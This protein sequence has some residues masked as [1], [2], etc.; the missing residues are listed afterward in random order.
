MVPLYC[1]FYLCLSHLLSSLVNDTQL[2]LSYP[3]WLHSYIYIYLF[4]THIS[5]CGTEGVASKTDIIFIKHLDV[6]N[7]C[8]YSG[9]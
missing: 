7:S 5:R 6:L 4:K 3:N 9:D 1:T 8:K 2:S